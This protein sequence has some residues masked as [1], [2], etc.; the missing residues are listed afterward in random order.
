MYLRVRG[1]HDLETRQHDSSVVGSSQVWSTMRSRSSVGRE[2]NIVVH[3]EKR[4]EVLTPDPNGRGKPQYKASV[5]SYIHN[6]P[7]R[8]DNTGNSLEQD[9]Y[10]AMSYLRMNV[11]NSLYFIRKYE[12]CAVKKKDDGKRKGGTLSLR[13]FSQAANRTD[14]RS[15]AGPREFGRPAYLRTVAAAV[16][17]TVQAPPAM[18]F[19][20]ALHD[21]IPTA[22]LLTE[23][24][25]ANRVNIFD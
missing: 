16:V 6:G 9:N 22:V 24:Y 18:V 5:P 14:S 2:G 13:D 4:D 15:L 20:Q 11:T 10:G 7:G 17:D 1:I 19:L 23:S 21:Q 8:K 25:E 3:W 12:Q